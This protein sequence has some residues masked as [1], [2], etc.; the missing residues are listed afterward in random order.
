MSI[1]GAEIPMTTMGITMKVNQIMIAVVI[2]LATGA[3]PIFGF[4][5]GSG[6][7]VRV[8]K[9]LKI[10]LIIAESVLICAFLL[11]QFAPMSVVSI[12]G[13]ESQLYNE[14]AVKCM[15]TFLMLCCINGFQLVSGIFFQAIGKPAFSAILSLSRQVLFLIPAMFILPTFM[16]VE[17]VLWAGPVADGMAF[18]LAITLLTINLRK[19]K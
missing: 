8:K 10:T 19:M 3:Q 4:N 7:T 6:Q 17:G 5:Y 11:F 15:R 2:G 12:F 9:T 1:Y 16:G 18:I 13:S 14:F